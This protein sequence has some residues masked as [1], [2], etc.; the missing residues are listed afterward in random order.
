[1]LPPLALGS[2]KILKMVLAEAFGSS[3]SPSITK[4]EGTF[5]LSEYFL[6]Q[7]DMGPPLKIIG[8]FK[9]TESG[10]RRGEGREDTTQLPEKKK[11]KIKTFWLK[12]CR[13]Y[14]HLLSVWLVVRIGM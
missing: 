10:E 12:G 14:G 3:L 8:S 11:K 2:G 7:R 5:P 9:V 6:K 13:K 1:M 4:G